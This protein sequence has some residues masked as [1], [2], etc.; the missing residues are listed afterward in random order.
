MR[1][2]VNGYRLPIGSTAD[3]FADKIFLSLSSGDYDRMAHMSFDLYKNKLN[4]KRWGEEVT[5]LLENA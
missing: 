5:L 2:G 3:E 4:W 1:N